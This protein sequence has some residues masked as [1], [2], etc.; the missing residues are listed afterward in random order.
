MEKLANKDIKKNIAIQNLWE[1][2]N[3]L[4]VILVDIKTLT[5]ENT[6]KHVTKINTLSKQ[7]HISIVKPFFRINLCKYI[8]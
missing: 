5:G 8:C 7:L 4:T 3:L 2:L 6:N 1:S